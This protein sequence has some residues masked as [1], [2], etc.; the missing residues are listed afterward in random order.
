[1]VSSHHIIKPPATITYACV[2]L[3]DVVC[4]ALIITDEDDLE[5]VVDILIVYILVIVKKKM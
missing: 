5:V 4:I 1:M 3:H 2:V